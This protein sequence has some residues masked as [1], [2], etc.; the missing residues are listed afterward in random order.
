MRRT[1]PRYAA[2]L[3]PVLEKACQFSFFFHS[4]FNRRIITVS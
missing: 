4:R 3:L 2:L 1:Y